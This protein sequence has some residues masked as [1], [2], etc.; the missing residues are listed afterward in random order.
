MSADYDLRSNIKAK[1]HQAYAVVS[2]DQTPTAIDTLDWG[3]LTFE[4]FVDAG[5]I[6]FSGTNKIEFKMQHSDDNSTF[7]AVTDDD[8]IRGAAD[9]AVDSNGTVRSLIAAHAAADTSPTLHGYRGKK[10]YVRILTDFSGTHGTGTGIYI[11]AVQ[12]H[13]YHKPFDQTTRE[14]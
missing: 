7:V 10:R 9:T 8:V 12:G 5:G 13:P 4:I 2:T 3:S 1:V 14:T 11:S 6:T